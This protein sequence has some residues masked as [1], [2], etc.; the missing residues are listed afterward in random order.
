[1][2]TITS[3]QVRKKNKKIKKMEARKKSNAWE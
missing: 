1:M 2:K 3:K